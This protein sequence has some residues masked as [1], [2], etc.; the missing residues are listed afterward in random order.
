MSY[1]SVYNGGLGFTYV[2]PTKALADYFAKYSQ[3]TNFSYQ[4][5]VG[6]LKSAYRDVRVEL[7]EFRSASGKLEARYVTQEDVMRAL[8]PSFTQGRVQLPAYY[9]APPSG[10]SY[11]AP[12]QEPNMLYWNNYYEAG[13]P[14]YTSQD[15]AASYLNPFAYGGYGSQELF[16]LGCGSYGLARLG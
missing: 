7:P 12:A 1:L 11:G 15:V 4:D 2:D 16:G 3:G 10:A 9:S 14:W 5:P 6:A 8:Q 13:Q